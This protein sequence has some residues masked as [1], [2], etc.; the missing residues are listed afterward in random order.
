ML[1]LAVATVLGSRQLCKSTL[2]VPDSPTITK[3]KNVEAMK[4]FG[5]RFGLRQHLMVR[6][7]GVQIGC[8][9]RFCAQS[10]K[11]RVEKTMSLRE[12]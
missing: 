11:I 2:Q 5:S 4:F 3:C 10:C 6:V 1:A 12:H 8:H 9:H 7:M